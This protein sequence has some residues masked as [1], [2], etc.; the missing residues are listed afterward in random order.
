MVA[1][2]PVWWHSHRCGGTRTDVMAL[3]LK[4]TIDDKALDR[5]QENV[6]Q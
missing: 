6:L 5:E 3:G 1:L 2:A 4:A